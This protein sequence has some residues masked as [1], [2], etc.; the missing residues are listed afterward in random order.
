MVAG[1]IVVI[2]IVTVCEAKELTFAWNFNKEF[3]EMTDGFKI[4]S[5]DTL[6]KDIPKSEVEVFKES[7]VLLN[8]TFDSDPGS[9]YN[10][11]EGSWT[12]DSATKNMKIESDRFMVVFELPAG[13]ESNMAFWFWPEKGLGDMAQ[14]YVYNK[15]EAETAATGFGSYYELRFG[16][17]SGIRYSNFRKCYDGK[18]GGVDPNGAF[19]LPRY[20]QC[21]I[22]EDQANICNG[23]AIYMT[24]MGGEYGYYSTSIYDQKQKVWT[25][26]GGSDSKALNVNKLEIILNSQT[27]WIDNIVIGGL[28]EL[29]K[30][31][32]VDVSQLPMYFTVSAYNGNGESAKSD[33]YVYDAETGE[34]LF[35]PNF[36]IKNIK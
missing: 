16:S 28:M 12:W 24:W 27:G 22:V 23:Y 36:R 25:E 20:P 29:R 11:T 3:L 10:V 18:Y 30:K 21:T 34:P 35:P 32:D 33:A 1:L 19:A 4:Y 7:P 26:V 17:T 15:D 5:G 13:T 8:E 6:I 31:I 14:L 2:W 9:K